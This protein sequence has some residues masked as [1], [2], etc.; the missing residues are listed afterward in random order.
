VIYEVEI[1][2]NNYSISIKMPINHISI[3][4]VLMNILRILIGGVVLLLTVHAHATGLELRLD[5][6]RKDIG[7]NAVK[8]KVMEPHM[9]CGEVN[10]TVTYVGIPLVKLMQYYFPGTWEGFNGFIHFYA[11]DGYLASVNA[12]KARKQDAYLTFERADGKP[13]I[14]DNERQNERDLPLGP[15]YLVWD[16]LRNE[17]LQKQGAYGWPYKVVS[18][19]LLPASAYD[20][21]LSADATPAARAG[22][23]DWKTYCMNC[24]R[25]DGVG[26]MKNPVNLRQLVNGKSRDELRAWINSPG[27]IRPGT[28][29]PPLNVHLGK[30]ERS[31]VIERIIDYLESL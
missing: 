29:M 22:F 31:Q 11:S 6:V 17:D 2:N 7:S 28:T 25:I 23:D 26:G 4:N 8:I 15:F 19:E 16:N 24:H 14:I 20:K 12:N 1:R 30:Q 3:A 10:C 13:F 5:Q 21:L 18:I 27:S 9:K